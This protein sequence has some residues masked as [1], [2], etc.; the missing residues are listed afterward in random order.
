MSSL[1][2]L[3]ILLAGLVLAWMTHR[4]VAK[5]TIYEYERGLKYVKGKF[6]GILE[7]GQY[8]Y[9]GSTTTIAKVDIRPYFVP[10]S[11]QEVLTADSVSLKLSLVCQYKVVDPDTAVNKVQS[12][13]QALYQELQLALREVVGGSPVDD[14][15]EKRGNFGA[16]VKDMVA[17]KAEEMGLELISA[18]VKDIMFPGSLKQVFS[19]VVK[20]RKEGLAALERA[21]GETAALRNLANA[22]RMI[23]NNPKLM[24]LR[25]LHSLSESNGNTVI[26]NLSPD[27][28]ILPVRHV[29]PDDPGRGTDTPTAETENAMD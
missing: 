25:L 16:Q 15:L 26:L 23:E 14:L 13:D 27:S 11:G 9:L 24:P 22:A 7:P 28:S 8:R 10:I 18:S 29:E 1:T 2:P 5:T 19:Q 4:L 6:V 21:R 12:Y 17:P 20:A 3:W